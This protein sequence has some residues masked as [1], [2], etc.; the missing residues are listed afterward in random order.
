MKD[1]VMQEGNSWSGYNS[2]KLNALVGT[3]DLEIRDWSDSSL[4]LQYIRLDEVAFKS[5]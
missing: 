5:K 3:I 2:I 1:I 4:A